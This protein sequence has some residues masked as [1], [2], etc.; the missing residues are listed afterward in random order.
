MKAEV[1]LTRSYRD[2]LLA[3][4]Y[5]P[6]YHFAIPDDLG[7]PESVTITSISQSRQIFS[8]AFFWNLE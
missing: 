3:D 5:R 1:L 8:I 7:I 4:E 6:T 2:R